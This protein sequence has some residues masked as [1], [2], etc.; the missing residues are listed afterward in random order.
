MGAQ[1]TILSICTHICDFPLQCRA[2]QTASCEKNT[3]VVSFQSCSHKPMEYRFRRL[4]RVERQARPGRHSGLGLK[5]P[6]VEIHF[7]V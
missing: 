7:G 3:D 2:S 5:P 4:G 1:R 6:D